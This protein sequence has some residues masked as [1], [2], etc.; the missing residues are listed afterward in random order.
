MNEICS[1]SVTAAID[2]SRVPINLTTIG[3]L[4]SPITNVRFAGSDAILYE[5]V[6][7]GVLR[8]RLDNM[9]TE[10]LLDIAAVVIFLYLLLNQAIK[11]T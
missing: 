9:E 3:K 5:N 1:I 2:H 7:K 8:L 6:N 4:R 10:T 11:C